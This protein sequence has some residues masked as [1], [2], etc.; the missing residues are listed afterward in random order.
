MYIYEKMNE[1]K[2]AQG[3]M[4]GFCKHGSEPSL[5]KGGIF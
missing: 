2:V 5:R 3:P 4:P 1:I